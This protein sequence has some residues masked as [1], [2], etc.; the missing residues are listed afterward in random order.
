M[1][2]QMIRNAGRLRDFE[3]IQYVVK[4]CSCFNSRARI[5]PNIANRYLSPSVSGVLGVLDICYPKEGSGHKFPHLAVIDSC[6]RFLIC[7]PVE[8]LVPTAVIA[9]FE[10]RWMA[11]LGRPRFL[12][13]EGVAWHS[14]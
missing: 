1:L 12:I 7:V 3:I 2:R 10:L 8:S 6:Y 14:I 11:F 9:C 13:K 4:K 5:S